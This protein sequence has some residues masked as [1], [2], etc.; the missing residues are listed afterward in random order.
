MSRAASDLRHHAS[1]LVCS[2]PNSRAIPPVE[3]TA[4][5]RILPGENWDKDTRS[6]LTAIGLNVKAGDYILAVNGTAV[7]TLPNIYDALVGTADKQVVL[8]VNSKPTDAG[9]RDVT[10][11]PTADESPLYYLEWVQHNIDYVNKKTDGKVGYLHIPDMGQPGLNEFTKRYF[12]QIHKEGAHRRR[13]RQWRRLCL[14]SGHRAT[15]PRSGHGGHG[16]QWQSP[17]PTHRRPSLGPMVTLIDEFSASDGDIFPYRFKTLG[18]GKLIGKRTWGG[19][20]GIRNP[21]PLIDGGQLFKPE[22]APY[23]K[24]GKG[25]II[26]GHGVDPDIV[27]DNDPAKEFHGIDQQLDR[28]IEEV[29]TEMKTKGYHL[30]P[31]P[32]FPNRNPANGGSSSTNP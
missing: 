3:P 11:V 4:S 7:S 24:E 25:W 27:V 28:G 1:R 2:A 18:L 13:A 19:V 10:V 26:E 9:A 8:R 5:T 30:P 32:P 20:I 23:S 22:F 16:A 15:A 12:P 14:A 6:P 17:S 31:I 21:L 29:Q